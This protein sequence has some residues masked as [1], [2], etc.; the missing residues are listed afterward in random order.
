MCWPTGVIPEFS[1]NL[2]SAIGCDAI[3]KF[4]DSRDNLLN[5]WFQFI[6]EADILRDAIETRQRVDA[7]DHIVIR[8]LDVR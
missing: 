2:L 4:A 6:T 5:V 7:T 3:F 8:G 1:H